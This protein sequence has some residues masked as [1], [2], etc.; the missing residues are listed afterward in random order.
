MINLH[1]WLCR[2]G[3]ALVVFA[4]AAEAAIAD[5]PTLGEPVALTPEEKAAWAAV[6]PPTPAAC[7]DACRDFDWKNVPPVRLAVR[8]GNFA[9]PPTGAG[10]YSLHDLALGE[11]RDKPP[12]FPYA[13]FALMQPPFYD[14]DFRYLDDP[15]NTQ[16]DFF[17]PLHRIY[18][19]DHLLFSTG[20]HASYRCRSWTAGSA[21]RTTN[22]ACSARGCSAI[23]GTRIASAPTSSSSAP[24][25]SIRN[26][27]RCPSIATTPTS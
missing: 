9:I 26:C 27:R 6:P 7:P 21:A 5:A 8:V 25:R 23:F 15:K 17:D 19:G 2:G 12:R 10:Y 16:H 11:Y 22:T 18:V 3:A 20:G 13:A 24:N 1:R 4:F 14:V